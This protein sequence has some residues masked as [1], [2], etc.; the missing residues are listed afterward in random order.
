MVASTRLG[1][2]VT[3][4]R[5][6]NDISVWNPRMSANVTF[7]H[8]LA[9]LLDRPLHANFVP[10][11]AVVLRQDLVEGRRSAG[12][13]PARSHRPQ[14]RHRRDGGSRQGHHDRPAAH[15]HSH[16]SQRHHD[17]DQACQQ[18]HHPG[19]ERHA[20]HPKLRKARP[21]PQQDHARDNHGQ[22]VHT[23]ASA[24]HFF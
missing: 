15:P 19:I 4:L 8:R 12:G 17:G 2:A 24:C 23:T 13:L 20:G 5:A 1:G 7:V 18:Y 22:R 16:K 21:D 6:R 10:L 14:Q 11:A 3:R 9:N